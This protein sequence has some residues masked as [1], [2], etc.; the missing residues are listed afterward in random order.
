[1]ASDISPANVMM[2]TINSISMTELLVFS[3]L[4]IDAIRLLIVAVVKDINTLKVK[5]Y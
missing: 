2:A 1:M 5:K 3:L 4:N